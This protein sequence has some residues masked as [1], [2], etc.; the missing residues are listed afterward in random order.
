M[1]IIK[2]NIEHLQSVIKKNLKNVD[3]KN[4]LIKTK[5]IL[6]LKFEMQD[7]LIISSKEM[8]EL[9]KKQIAFY[10]INVEIMRKELISYKIIINNL[11][12]TIQIKLMK[13][14]LMIKYFRDILRKGSKRF[15]IKKFTI[16]NLIEENKSEIEKGLKTLKKIKLNKIKEID[17]IEK[18][19][20][21]KN[22]IKKIN[23]NEVEKSNKNKNKIKE[24][25]KN[26]VEE[27]KLKKVKKF[28]IIIL[29][30]VFFRIIEFYECLCALCAFDFTTLI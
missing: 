29:S 18:L 25:N 10:L 13:L 3:Q 11:S 28:K 5:I 26:E 24:T 1:I 15:K 14:K 8:I 9:L 6:I 27:T 30:K 7:K 23:K 22:K 17:L 12:I 21:N 4:P 19:N 2:E 16:I 20:K